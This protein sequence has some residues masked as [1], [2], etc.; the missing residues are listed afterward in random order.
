VQTESAL[1]GRSC[2]HGLAGPVLI[3]KVRREI[4]ALGA[5]NFLQFGDICRFKRAMSGGNAI[6]PF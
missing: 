6:F 2:Q 3:E 1:F 4:L 5:G